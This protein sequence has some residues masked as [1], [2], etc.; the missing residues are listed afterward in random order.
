MNEKEIDEKFSKLIRE[1]MDE[2]TFI[3]WIK[4]WLDFSDI[5]ERAEEWNTD[6][7]KETLE[8]FKD[9]IEVS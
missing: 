9:L 8:E 2:D 7:K 5:C 6:L 3:E 4:T 1:D